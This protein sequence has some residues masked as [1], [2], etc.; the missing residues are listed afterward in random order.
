MLTTKD[1]AKGG[2]LNLYRRNIA[3]LQ[4]LFKYT[5]QDKDG[6]IIPLKETYL[7]DGDTVPEVIGKEVDGPWKK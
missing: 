4:D 5:V 2:L 6:F 7:E 1:P 3:P